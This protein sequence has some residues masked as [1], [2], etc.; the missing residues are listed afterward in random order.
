MNTAFFGLPDNWRKHTAGIAARL[1]MIVSGGLAALL[2]WTA[3]DLTWKLLPVPDLPAAP[4]PAAIRPDAARGT[5]GDIN[6][7]IELHLFGVP[8]AAAPNALPANLDAPETRLNLVLRGI[9]ASGNP[10]QSRAIIASGS[11]ERTYSIKMEV[12]GGASIHAILPDRIILNRDGSLETLRLPREDETG[13]DLSYTDSRE[14]TPLP[15]AGAAANVAELRDSIVQDPQKLTEL[16]RLQPVYENNQ[17]TGYRIYPGRDRQRFTA[18]GLQSGDLVT[19]I[20]GMPLSD[21][22]AGIKLLQQLDDTESITLTI[23]RDGV[24]QQINLSATR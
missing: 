17:L 15:P 4:P 21:P 2:A 6:P 20:N 12:P 3:A 16:V 18:F 19:A 10:E 5:G 1:P 14:S 11:E 7:L 13:V 23:Q 8:Q 24:E 9:V 22:T